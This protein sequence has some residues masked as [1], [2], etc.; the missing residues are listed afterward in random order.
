MTES[1]SHVSPRIEE[2]EQTV[3]H[4]KKKRPI[5][6]SVKAT[7]NKNPLGAGPSSVD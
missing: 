5:P 4:S 3:Y 6:L 1:V 7:L 2:E